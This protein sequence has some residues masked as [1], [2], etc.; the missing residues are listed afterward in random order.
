MANIDLFDGCSCVD[1]IMR[2]KLKK[3]NWGSYEDESDRGVRYN[4]RIGPKKLNLGQSQVRWGYM[5]IF[6]HIF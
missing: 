6:F 5:Y 3:T 1:S 2:N 4:H